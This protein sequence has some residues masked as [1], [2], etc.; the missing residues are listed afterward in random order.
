MENI[1]WGMS[2][3]AFSICPLGGERN[4][5]GSVKPLLISFALHYCSPQAFH[6]GI[7][8]RFIN[9]TDKYNLVNLIADIHINYYT[10]QNYKGRLSWK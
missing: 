7:C 3:T 10:A 2:L 5:N 9:V 4:E 8:K 6:C 1:Q